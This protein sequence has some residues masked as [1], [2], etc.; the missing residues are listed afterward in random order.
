MGKILS[1]LS[2][3]AP[4]SY[5]SLQ[6]WSVLGDWSYLKSQY[7]LIGGEIHQKSLTHHPEEENHDFS[8]LLVS[9]PHSPVGFPTPHQTLAGCGSMA[10][11]VPKQWQT[12]LSIDHLLIQ[13]PELWWIIWEY[14][15]RLSSFLV[16]CSR[17]GRHLNRKIRSRLTCSEDCRLCTCDGAICSEGSLSLPQAGALYSL[18]SLLCSNWTGAQRPSFPPHGPC[19]IFCILEH[20]FFCTV[21]LKPWEIPN[22]GKQFQNKFAELLGWVWVSSAGSVVPWW[23]LCAVQGRDSK[24]LQSRTLVTLC[25]AL[26]DHSIPSPFWPLGTHF[27]CVLPCLVFG[28]VLTT[29]TSSLKQTIKVKHLHHHLHRH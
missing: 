29:D 9:F 13:F 27:G 20:Y 17:E 22:W 10:F 5:W 12:E 28:S 14:G 6:S 19:H 18:T 1:P 2:G 16:L 4:S 7:Q 15:K 24:S 23:W 8:L 3:G 25:V 26:C 21:C 11:M